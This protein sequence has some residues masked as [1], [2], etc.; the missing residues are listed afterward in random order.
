MDFIKYQSTWQI[1]RLMLTVRTLRWALY[2]H[3]MKAL[4][5]I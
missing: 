4:L 5:E 2:E 1:I 3:I